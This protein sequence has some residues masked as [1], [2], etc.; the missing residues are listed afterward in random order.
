MPRIELKKKPTVDILVPSPDSST[1]RA[2]NSDLTTKNKSTFIDVNL[3]PISP[4]MDVCPTNLEETVDLEEIR[5][6]RKPK[7]NPSIVIDSTSP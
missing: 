2:R 5:T 6:S 3:R 1:D 4:T 7:P